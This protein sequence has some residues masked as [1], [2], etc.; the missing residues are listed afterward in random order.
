MCTFCGLEY[1][2]T[3]H[4]FN[5]YFKS[6]TVW[7][8]VSNLIAKTISFSNGFLSGMWLDAKHSSNSAFINS[9]IAAT[10]WFIWKA[11][12]NSIFQNEPPGFNSITCKALAHANE[13]FLA[14]TAQMERNLILSNFSTADGLFLFLSTFCTR[15]LSMGGASFYISNS[16]NSISIIGCCPH[17]GEF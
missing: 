15:D 2:T 6:Q 10:A 5:H 7:T 8:S 13:Y 17:P 4:L 12:C 9:V 16:N 11:R 3:E 1:E 14:S